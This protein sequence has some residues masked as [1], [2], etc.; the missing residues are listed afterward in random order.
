M[1][2]NDY[3]PTLLT[4]ATCTGT[5]SNFKQYSNRIYVQTKMTLRSFQQYYFSFV[6]EPSYR[7]GLNLHANGTE[8]M[9]NNAQVNRLRLREVC[10]VSSFRTFAF[11]KMYYYTDVGTYVCFIYC[12]ITGY[13][14][15]P[16]NS[17]YLYCWQETKG[18]GKTAQK[19]H[20][21]RFRLRI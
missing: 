9:K 12:W 8:Q 10:S 18:V 6:C 20:S 19:F 7:S 17:R 1:I 21:F 4:K 11:S 2:E 5:M 13:I 15:R 16:Q 3:A 14:G